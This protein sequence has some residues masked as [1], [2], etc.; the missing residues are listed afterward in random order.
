MFR[1]SR[2][3]LTLFG[4]VGIFILTIGSMT[5]NRPGIAL[6]EDAPAAPIPSATSST[7]TL[8]DFLTGYTGGTVPLEDYT[9]EIREF[10]L[11]IHEVETEIAP[12]VTTTQW[13]FGSPGEEPSVPG[14]EIRV[15]EGDLVRITLRNTHT[16]PHSFHPHGIISVAQEMDGVSATSHQILPGEAF[17]YEFV[18]ANPGTHAYH[19]H[20]QTYTH[21]DMGMYGA[22]IVEPKDDTL[23]VWDREYSLT[24]DEWDSRQ[25]ALAAK[26]VSEPNY[27]LINGKAAPHNDKYEVPEGE[28]ALFR[29]TNV[30]YQPHSLH[31][32]GMSFLVVTKDG[33]NLP[34]PYQA[35]TLPILPGER[36][37]LLIKGRDGAF[38]FHDH[39]VSNVTND[40]VYPG[41]MLTVIL[42]GEAERV[43]DSP[44]SVY[45]GREAKPGKFEVAANHS[46]DN[47]SQD[48]PSHDTGAAHDH[49]DA[50]AHVT[51]VSEDVTTEPRAEAVEGEVLEGEVAVDITEFAFEMPE[52]RIKRGTT[53]TWTNRDAAL[54]TVTEGLPGA[55]PK[56]RAF[57]SS[58]EAEGVPMM[59]NQGESWS[60]T[61][62]EPGEYDYYC[63]PHP[64]MT[65][66]VT[67][68]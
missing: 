34:Q 2:F 1:A 64:F 53:V 19:C 20:I 59:L 66:K 27:F 11:E 55:D 63:L 26:H 8:Q 61:F 24:L 14:P 50:S 51:P 56:G 62:D 54:H 23:K 44:L 12:G 3:S 21:L 68:E 28:V 4:T 45:A 36:Y 30:G 29:M 22:I 7:D 40:G 47:H 35:D 41:G 38:P 32:H 33:F 60:Y 67:V 17:T 9:G 49:A 52:L 46:H 58:L 42:G 65:A 18:A 15:T 13:A 16:Q 5:F 6:A 43:T 37:D 48:T 10:T 39:I 57:D 31:L 25:D